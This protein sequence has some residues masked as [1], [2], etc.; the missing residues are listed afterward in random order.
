MGGYKSVVKT[1]AAAFLAAYDST[2]R[3]CCMFSM[4]CSIF[5]ISRLL[6]MV[7]IYGI[8]KIDC[9]LPMQMEY[10]GLDIL[11]SMFCDIYRGQVGVIVACPNLN[12]FDFC[13]VTWPDR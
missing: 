13:L 11:I 4:F 12:N 8:C 1:L 9:F 2:T 6:H 7:Q 3:V 10:E 5:N